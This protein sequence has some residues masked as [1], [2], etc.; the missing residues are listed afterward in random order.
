MAAA[1]L[2]RICARCARTARE[3]AVA[4]HPVSRM[5]R[6]GFFA[7]AAAAALPGCATMWD[8]VTSRDFHVRSMWE[9][10]DPMTV[11]RESTDGDKRAKAM[12]ELKEPRANGG[13]DV[14]Q[15]RVM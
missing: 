12:R 2:K 14:E 4:L 10:T 3:A 15:D 5:A 8:D 6:H 11:L 9:R 7:F 1:I 13:N